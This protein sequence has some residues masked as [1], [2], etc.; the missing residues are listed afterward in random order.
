MYKNDGVSVFHTL[1]EDEDV[2]VVFELAP[3]FMEGVFIHTTVKNFSL[4]KMKKFKQ[5]WP[6]IV[7]YI[8]NIG[9]Y[10]IYALPT[11]DMAEK[12]ERQFSFIDTGVTYEGQ[13]I[14]KYR[15]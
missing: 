12:W 8:H 5:L 14:M 11:D 1:Y 6:H 2:H 3:T 4:S 9:V 7:G 15:N 10:N 13:K